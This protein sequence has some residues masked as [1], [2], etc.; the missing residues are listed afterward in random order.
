MSVW[1]IL[2]V[3]V[4]LSILALI[5][6]RHKLVW[7][8]VLL[9]IVAGIIIIAGMKAAMV[10]GLT[11]DT[12]YFS[13]YVV[14]ATHYEDWNEYIHRTCTQS[15][16]CGKSTCTRTYDCSYVQYHSAYSEV[17]LNTGR[18]ITIS[19]NEFNRL[20]RKF[21]NKK[22]KNMH[23]S[24]HTN[25][26]DAYITK[27]PGGFNLLETYEWS[28]SY[29]NKPQTAE[30]IFHFDPLQPEDLKKVYDYPKIK[31]YEQDQCLGCSQLDNNLLKKYNATHGRKYQIR[32]WVLLYEGQSRHV[33]E[34]QRQYWKNG[35]KNE[36]VICADKN[37]EWAKVFS[38]SDDKRLEAELTDIFSTP[39][40]S[41]NQK[42]RKSFKLIPSQ[43][44]RKEFKDFNYIDV[45][46]KMSQIYW[47]FGVVTFISIGLIIFGVVN[48]IEQE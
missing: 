48:D 25:D 22:F 2:L 1:L 47:I 8:E 36:V 37:G 16:K 24:Y 33:A 18:K 30:T 7:F 29:D 42:I 13:G 39:N 43:W 20:V 45:Q 40:L 5:I 3:P 44:K 12:E 4:I 31:N 34:L 41:T 38:W 10:H 32:V 9:P 6:Y 23:R 28:G 27:F 21:G 19:K 46:L 15:Y 35:N 14:K 11:T 26:G 17:T